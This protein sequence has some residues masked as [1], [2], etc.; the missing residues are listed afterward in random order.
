M[1]L[2]I[3]LFDY[4]GSWSSPWVEA[5]YEVI[6]LDI[7]HQPELFQSNSN[8]TKIGCDIRDW[9][10]KEIDSNVYGVIAAVPCTSYSIACS[11]IWNVKD[12]DG[13]TDISNSITNRTLEIINHF[14]PAFWAI[15]N[16]ASSRIERCIPFLKGK[17]LLTFQPYHYGDPY[18][19]KT[20]LWGDFNSSL[21]K[22]EVEVK[23]KNSGNS[24]GGG[25]M[26]IDFF[27]RSRGI[28]GKYNETRSITPPG[29]AKAFFEANKIYYANM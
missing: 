29:F 21:K 15:E 3:S 17:R 5:G 19:K 12:R 28:K 24:S 27:N 7:K 25:S 16:P 4:S 6:M 10:Y 1:D 2:I 8:V 13:R 14:D 26:A 23:F 20:S 9:N 18:T 11:S 22:T